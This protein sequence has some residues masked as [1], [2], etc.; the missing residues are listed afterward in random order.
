MP[1]RTAADLLPLPPVSLLLNASLFIDFD[2][3]LVELIDRPDAVTVDDGLIDL[4]G[5]VSAAL[6]GRVAIVSGRSIEQI[7]HFLGD[8]ARNLAVAGSHGVERRLPDGSISFPELPDFTPVAEALASFT[9]MHPGTIIEPKRYGVALHYRLA[10]QSEVEAHAMVTKLAEKFGFGVQMGKMMAELK[11]AGGNKG[12][13]VAAFLQ[14][15]VMAGTTPWF[16]GDDMT[17]EDGFAI[18]RASGGGGI[19]VGPPRKTDAS[20]GL[21]D[22]SA[23]RTWLMEAVRSLA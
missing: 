15:P 5:R 1:T 3:T 9:A 10:P 13:A 17:D 14:E 2:G 11:V 6:P 19:L 20:Y 8:Q 22:V 12:E 4:L 18:A 21:S 23:V 16:I 7:D